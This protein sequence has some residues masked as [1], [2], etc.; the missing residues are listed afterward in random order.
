M[1]S[2]T[3]DGVLKDLELACGSEEQ[4]APRSS[5]STNSHLETR[6]TTTSTSERSPSWKQVS[7]AGLKAKLTSNEVD[8]RKSEPPPVPQRDLSSKMAATINSNNAV[9]NNLNELD[10]LLQDL[11]NARLVTKS[12][13]ERQHC[14]CK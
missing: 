2:S 12:T 9:T 13:F 6:S 5:T 14:I 1:M 4:R 7:E 8:L 10:V 11:S 3:L